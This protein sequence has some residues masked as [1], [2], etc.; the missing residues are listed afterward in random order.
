MGDV[1]G[2]S[3]FPV[4]GLG[5]NRGICFQKHN[6]GIALDLVLSLEF[7]VLCLESCALRCGTGKV[8]D[9]Q[10]QVLSGVGLELGLRENLLLEFDAPGAPV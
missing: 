5:H 10:H 7:L 1:G 4:S 8:R 9:E 3:A 2:G 6:R